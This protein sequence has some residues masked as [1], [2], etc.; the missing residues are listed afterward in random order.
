[1]ARTVKGTITDASTG[2]P[3]SGAL[4][5]AWDSDSTSG[6]DFMGCGCTNNNGQYAIQYASGHWDPAPHSWTYWRPDIYIVV[7]IM[8]QGG[9]VKVGKSGVRDNRPH[10]FDTT[11]NL[12]VNVPN[13]HARTCWGR[14][15]YEDDGSAARGVSVNAFDD[16]PNNPFT[17][18]PDRLI[19]V[20]RPSGILQYISADPEDD[21]MGSTTTDNTGNYVI[22]YEAKHW[23]P[24][25]HAWTYWRPDIFIIVNGQAPRSQWWQT[26]G[27]SPTHENVR[28]RDGVRIDLAVKRPIVV[29]QAI[30]TIAAI[31]LRLQTKIMK[32]EMT[33]DEA[34]KQRAREIW[35][36]QSA[37]P[38]NIPKKEVNTF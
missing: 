8:T 18:D 4:V 35:E 27:I 30:V 21:F 3:I 20:G 2:N 34:R 5:Y 26:L 24:A 10:R 1:M 31:E 25:P 28:H 16:D 6:D 13:P 37:K 12:S 17:Q 32:G 7:Y 11:I 29:E 19:P 36:L 22:P 33:S 38:L 14:I 9:W 23:D 15:T